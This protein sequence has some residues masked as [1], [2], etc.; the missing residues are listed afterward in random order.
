MTDRI[1]AIAEEASARW[2]RWDPT[3]WREL[4][5]GPGRRLAERLLATGTPDADAAALTEVFLRLG[6]EGIGLGYLVPASRIGAETFLGRAWRTWLPDGLAR[7]PPDGRAAAIA[8]CWNL[9]ENLENSPA[10]LRRV[11]ELALGD[12]P[13]VARLEDAVRDA[14]VALTAPPT[15]A[16]REHDAAIDWVW[17]GDVDPTF[18]PGRARFVTPTV[19]CVLDRLRD[20]RDG[21]AAHGLGLWLRDQGPVV[22]GPMPPP[23]DDADLPGGPAPHGPFDWTRRRA[24]EPRLTRAFATAGNAARAVATLETSQFVVCARPA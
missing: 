24:R 23:P 20:G 21:R 9:G 11:V 4:L 7:V 14:G 18:L 6:A 3:T 17:L 16:L 13:D 1:A 15:A 2:V 5:D 10:W 19:V 22:L 8:Q 12:V